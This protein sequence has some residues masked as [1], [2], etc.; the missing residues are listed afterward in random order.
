MLAGTLKRLKA[1][2]V[3]MALLLG[4]GCAAAPP[5]VAR[6]SLGDAVDATIALVNEEGRPFCAGAMVDGGLAVTAAHCVEDATHVLVGFR[7]DQNAHRRFPRAYTFQVL[8]ADP[9]QDIAVLDPRSLRLPPHSTLS[10]A[11]AAPRAGESV[12]LI[13]HPL[14]LTFSVTRGIVSAPSRNDC[15][16]LLCELLDGEKQHW[17]QVDAGVFFGNSGGPAVN[18]RGQLVG[19]ASFL[20]AT[21]HLGG[22]VH[23]DEIR[24]ALARPTQVRTG[25][26][27]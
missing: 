6:T 14:G 27:R 21:P 15:S 26:A 23:V 25:R 17:T 16:D 1:A 18:R 5:R 11:A 19:V 4:L 13:G 3:G 9:V 22:V 12:W 20:A 8:Y 7:P 24:R 2:L 10:V